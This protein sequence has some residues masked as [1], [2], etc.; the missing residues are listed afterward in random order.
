M[1]GKAQ[2]TDSFV[3]WVSEGSP[4]GFCQG[5]GGQGG[6]GRTH[7]LPM[8]VSMLLGR[9]GR[10]LP[11]GTLLASVCLSL[12]HSNIPSLCG[13]SQAV[14]VPNCQ[15]EHCTLTRPTNRKTDSHSPARKVSMKPCVQARELGEHPKGISC[16][17]MGFK[18]KIFCSSSRN[19]VRQEDAECLCPEETGR[20]MRRTITKLTP[21][22]AQGEW[23]TGGRRQ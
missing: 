20:F 18:E 2:Y 17:K 9:E 16:P 11:V 12:G 14:I 19:A 7:R 15:G 10:H 1:E 5:S 22:D 3:C 13:F 6:A 23:K 4:R 21:G 8:G